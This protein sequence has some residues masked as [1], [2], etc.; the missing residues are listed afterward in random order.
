MFK[1]LLLFA[2]LLIPTGL[3]ADTGDIPLSSNFQ[4]NSGRPLDA[5]LVAADSTARLAMTATQVYNGMVVFQ[6][7]NSHSYQLQGSTYNW[8]DL[9]LLSTVLLSSAVAFGSA[10]NTITSDTNSFIWNDSSHTLTLQTKIVDYTTGSDG[11][12]PRLTLIGGSDAFYGGSNQT[13]LLRFWYPSFNNEPA[14]GMDWLDGPP[15]NN[16][17]LAGF[18]YDILNTQFRW[19]GVGGSGGYPLMSIIGPSFTNNPGGGTENSGLEFVFGSGPT[20]LP[21]V[22]FQFYDT[23]SNGRDILSIDSNY[24]GRA[25]VLNGYEQIPGRPWIRGDMF[26]VDGLNATLGLH[27]HVLMII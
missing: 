6:K 11:V 14:L 15:N 13:P 25:L 10:S 27:S 21:N 4:E 24:G 19:Y 20:S 8:V 1:K 23:G 9:G 5:K 3:L 26:W 12:N 22:D 16:V 2:S 18:Y 17:E 7:D